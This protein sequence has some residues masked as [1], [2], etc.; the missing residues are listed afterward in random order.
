MSS[1]AHLKNIHITTSV[2]LQFLYVKIEEISNVIIGL[3]KS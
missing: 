2:L 1:N 3:N